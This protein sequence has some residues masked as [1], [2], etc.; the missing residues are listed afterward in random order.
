MSWLDKRWDGEGIW[1]E[2][3]VGM[4]WVCVAGTGRAWIG[5]GW[6]GC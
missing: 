1:V 5:V 3:V 2:C 4:G 6:G